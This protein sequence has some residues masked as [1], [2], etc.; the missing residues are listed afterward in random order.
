MKHTPGPWET[1]GKQGY[2]VWANDSILFSSNLPRSSPEGRANA[3]LA[4]AAPELL[5]ALKEL[6]KA[7]V[8]ADGE[9]I[10][11]IEH[12]DTESCTQAVSKARAAIAKAEG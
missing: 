2:T 5:E 7:D 1:L 6:L 11:F 10:V 4:S 9:G 12:G 3:R 8:Y